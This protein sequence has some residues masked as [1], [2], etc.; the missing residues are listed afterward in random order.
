MSAKCCHV[1]VL[2]AGST[3]DGE[4]EEALLPCVI[5]YPGYTI[6]PDSHIDDKYREKYQVPFSPSLDPA[7]PQS[8]PLENS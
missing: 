8:R 2:L 6:A 1:K 4:I 3:E 5:D 7:P